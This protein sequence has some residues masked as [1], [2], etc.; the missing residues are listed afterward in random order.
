[1]GDGAGRPEDGEAAERGHG[2]GARVPQGARRPRGDPDPGHRHDRQQP[3]GQAERAD[4]EDGDP[5]GAHDR[6]PSASRPATAAAAIAGRTSNP[7]TTMCAATAVPAAAATAA[8]PP[9]SRRCGT[10]STTR[11][12]GTATA[13]CRASPSTCPTAVPRVTAAVQ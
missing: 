8:I 7:G 6:A 4:D 2:A 10:T 11:H 9:G 1:M 3:E 13:R 5:D 12:S